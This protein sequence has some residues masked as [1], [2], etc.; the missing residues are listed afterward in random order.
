MCGRYAVTASVEDLVSEFEIDDAPLRT[1]EPDYNVA[2]TKPVPVVLE[3]LR[4]LLL[5]LGIS[6]TS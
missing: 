6:G 3:R 1:F 2:P 4:G 5:G